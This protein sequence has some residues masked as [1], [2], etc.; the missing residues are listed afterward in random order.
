MN[1]IKTDNWNFEKGNSA[2]GSFH[3]I[4]KFDLADT[5]SLKLDCLDIHD[6]FIKTTDNCE[7]MF[8]VKSRRKVETILFHDDV[9]IAFKTG[10]RNIYI[11]Q[12]NKL[13]R[14]KLSDIPVKPLKAVGYKFNKLVH[15]CPV[16]IARPVGHVHVQRG[17]CLT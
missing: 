1:I 9:S 10:D 17:A 6:F 3:D 15:Y 13:Y 7:K 14:I 11:L 12:N 8:T 5:F 4:K 2:F 16:K